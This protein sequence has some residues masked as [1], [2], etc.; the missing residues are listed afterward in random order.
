[1]GMTAQKPTSIV[2]FVREGRQN[3]PQVLRIVKKALRKRPELAALRIVI[4]TAVGEGPVLAYNSLQEFD[5]RI[6]AVTFPP[7]FSV[8]QKESDDRYFPRIPQKLQAFFDGVGIPVLTGRLPF[9]GIEGIDTH[10][11]RMRLIKSVL[12]IFGGGFSLSVQAVLSACDR[13]ELTP[14]EEVI[15]ITG[16]SAAVMTATTTAKFLSKG[17]GLSINEIL[18]KPRNLTISRNLSDERASSA[19]GSAGRGSLPQSR[20]EK[21]LLPGPRPKDA[22]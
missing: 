16:D 5:P 4:F 1:M 20:S 18:C 8:K 15:S 14:G 10:N 22:P 9:D 3:L 6:I 7:D 21:T 19:V 17:G 12:G 11:D 13:G 2:Y